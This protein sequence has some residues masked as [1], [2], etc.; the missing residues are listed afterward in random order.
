MLLAAFAATGTTY[1]L[2][3]IASE[4]LFVSAY[5][6]EDRDA[7]MARLHLAAALNPYDY[8]VRA[9][10]A[11]YCS[12]ARWKG[13]GAG[14]MSALLAELAENPFALDLRRNLAGFLIEAGRIDAAK[15]EIAF[16]S[17][18]VPGQ[19]LVVPVNANP[20]TR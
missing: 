4:Q 12:E 8:H 10:P 20:A 5:R 1:A 11:A 18:F 9:G 17:K 6:L 7:A 2:I 16:I 13:S 19:H 14:C 15:A 3:G